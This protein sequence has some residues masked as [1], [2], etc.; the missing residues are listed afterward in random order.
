METL[1]PRE[2]VRLGIHAKL[3][4]AREQDAEHLLVALRAHEREC[5]KLT[6]LASAITDTSSWSMLMLDCARDSIRTILTAEIDW[7]ARAR[8]RIEEYHAHPESST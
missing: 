8:A 1:L 5:L 6:L 7:A 3:A 4:V 2:P